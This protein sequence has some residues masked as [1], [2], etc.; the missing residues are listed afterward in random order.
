M[1]K[2]YPEMY[3]WESCEREGDRQ[4]ER[5][6]TGNDWGRKTKKEMRTHTH[7]HTHMHTH[8]HTHT[9]THKWWPLFESS[10]VD[11]MYLHPVQ[12]IG[13]QRLPFCKDQD[14]ASYVAS[15]KGT[16]LWTII[17]YIYV[18]STNCISLSGINKLTAVILDL[19]S[20]N[21]QQ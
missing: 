20:I 12:T 9:H 2:S 18:E 14:A 19:A 10:E 13:S 5:Q 7:T 11:E 15:W 3:M 16:K 17:I 4:T 6:E 8:T 21:R 1:F